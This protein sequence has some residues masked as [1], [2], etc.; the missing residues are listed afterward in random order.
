MHYYYYYM[1]YV[2]YDTGI[3]VL[4]NRLNAARAIMPTYYL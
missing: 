4:K 2:N 3:Y 1:L